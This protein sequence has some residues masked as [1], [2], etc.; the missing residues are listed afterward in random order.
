MMMCDFG[1]GGLQKGVEPPKT[2]SLVAM[3]QVP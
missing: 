3:D 2:V 1:G